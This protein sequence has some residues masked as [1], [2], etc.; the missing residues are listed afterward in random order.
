MQ[1]KMPR[2][3]FIPSASRPIKREQ[4][5]GLL[6]GRMWLGNGADAPY[7]KENAEHF[8]YPTSFG[9]QKKREQPQ[10]LLRGRMWLG[11]GADAPYAKENAWHFLYPTSFGDQK[12]ESNHK[13]C[14]LFL[15]EVA[16]LELAASSTRNWRA[17]NCATPRNE[18]FTHYSISNRDEFVKSF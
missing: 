3:F 12:R 8:L 7:A 11:N 18:I 6:H 9:D 1:K 15:V 5:Q 16:G 10:G 14:S 2:I 17:T 4:P 13:G